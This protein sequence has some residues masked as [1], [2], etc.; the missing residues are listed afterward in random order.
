MMERQAQAGTSRTALVIAAAVSVLVGDSSRI[1]HYLFYPFTLLATWVHE[2][3]HGLTAIFVGGHFERL[4]IFADASGLAHTTTPAR[5][6]P[7]ALVSLGGLVAPPLIGA[8]VLGLARGP[9]RARLALTALAL[10]LFA[11]TV[12]WVRTP[13]GVIV[14][15]IVGL[16]AL[17]V[18]AWGSGREQLFLAQL[19]G[20]RLALDTL[21]RG[22]SYLFTTSVIIDGQERASD[23]H[24]VAVHLGLPQL[25]CSVTVSAV[26]VALVA[27]GL[28]AA[29][30]RPRAQR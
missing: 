10:A 7:S 19:I 22:L 9:R 13:V 14:M 25:L 20:L 5:N 17:A 12:L 4:E 2:C 11:T 24:D 18:A 8:L 15:P 23:I 28:Y 27:V 26:S 16:V 6:L 21:G 29:W 30:R 3:G 1:G